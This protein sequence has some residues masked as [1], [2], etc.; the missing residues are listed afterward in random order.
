[1]I[2]P[3]KPRNQRPNSSRDGSGSKAWIAWTTIGVVSFLGI[4]ALGVGAWR[5]LNRSHDDS[6]NT[7]A[8]MY[9]LLDT[10]NV[11]EGEIRAT[12]RPAM[13]R[14]NILAKSPEVIQA[15]LFPVIGH[16]KP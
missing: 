11:L 5:A 13:E 9:T 4:L 8:A 1:M 12:I 3:E 7:S 16:R 15:R 14:T 2:A 10:G 6:A